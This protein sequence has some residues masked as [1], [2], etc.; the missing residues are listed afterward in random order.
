MDSENSILFVNSAANELIR[1]AISQRP[2]TQDLL[3]Q[4][5]VFNHLEEDKI[6]FV[7]TQFMDLKM[8]DKKI[9]EEEAAFGRRHSTGSN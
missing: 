3:A 4:H 1:K 2:E 9:N 8:F 5:I 7:E 6:N